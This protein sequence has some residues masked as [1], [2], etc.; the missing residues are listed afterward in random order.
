MFAPLG[1][2]LL[3]YSLTLPPMASYA[4]SLSSPA[5]PP[6][7]PH[8]DAFRTHTLW[9]AVLQAALG[10]A[11][12][13]ITAGILAKIFN[14]SSSSSRPLNVLGSVGNCPKPVSCP[15][16]GAV[17]MVDNRARMGALAIAISVAQ[18]A[19]IAIWWSR[20]RE[21]P[22]LLASVLLQCAI[23]V[24]TMLVVFYAK[25]LTSNRF[26]YRGL[27]PWLA[28][29]L[30]AVQL[31]VCTCE[32]Y[33]SFF[34]PLHRDESVIGW[35]ASVRSNCL[36]GSTIASALLLL[37]LS[38][39]Q[40][41]PYFIR[42]LHGDASG[43]TPAA[44]YADRCTIVSATDNSTPLA[45][46]RTVDP[47]ELVDTL[48]Y[49]SSW[50]SRLSFSW[51][52]DL[53][54]KGVRRQLEYTDLY[55]LDDKD[56]PA[57]AWRRFQRHRRDGRSLITTLLITFAPELSL[58]CVLA[59]AE[60]V[61]QFSGPFFLQ[62]ILR[63]IDV[64]G[65]KSSEGEGTKTLRS[66]YLDAFGLLFFTLLTSVVSHQ[67]LWIGRQIGIRLK[68]LL[69]GELSAKTLRRRGKGSWENSDDAEKDEDGDGDDDDEASSASAAA[70]GKIMNLLTADFNR[71]TEVSAYMDNVYTMPIM[72]LIGIWYMYVLLGV[73]ALVG[74]SVSILFVPLSKIL[75][76]YL[77]KIET[78][79][80][81]LSDERVTVIT[82]LLQGIKAVKLF[83][84]ESRFLERVDERR[85]KQ[86]TYMWKMMTAWIRTELVSTLAPMFVLISIF[87]TY[88]AVY[89]NR[90]TA[91]IA[92]TSIS[93]FKIIRMVFEHLPGLLNWMIGGYVSLKRIDEYLQQAQVQDLEE[94]VDAADCNGGSEL[95]FA[96]ADLEWTSSS[97]AEA[98]ATAAPTP[99]GAV[100]EQTPLLVVHPPGSQSSALLENVDMVPFSLKNISLRF[101]AGGLSLIAGP[102]GSGKSSLLSALIGEMTLTSG[103]ILLPTA[104]TPSTDPVLGDL[105]GSGLAI[106]D[107]A[108][109]AQE[110]WLRNATIRENIL[111][112][113]PYS[114][115]RYEE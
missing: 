96:S 40:Q 85:E 80:N 57:H 24:L 82:E 68:G 16:T 12:L 86:L 8:D 39:V 62:R 55:R 109:V 29:A 108:Y 56:M 111:F 74:L 95:G 2:R 34:T 48:E 31:A 88:V 36:A 44:A 65:S 79:L 78:K 3:D 60:S 102:T 50:F 58:Q 13:T 7:T 30:V 6:W 101:P 72:M 53:L 107:I 98:D 83:G 93:V 59:L 90:L 10:A 89:G 73:S 1:Q 54:G 41:R 113:E 15:K 110:A 49:S 46:P 77:A 23:V 5:T 9:P 104:R 112:G 97:P 91:E 22:E 81:A 69:V 94:R 106:S 25:M 21:T 70:D 100:D 42:P 32:S 26:L 43:V 114:Q 61:L 4:F 18:T 115:Q 103:R 63:S 45:P 37:A 87:A 66:A 17:Q 11:L 84:W 19:V 20:S 28:P 64:L 71:V 38:M 76:R 67:T 75:F 27:F 35:A 92:F 51:P 105:T 14:R 47:A 99:P 33:F 52:N